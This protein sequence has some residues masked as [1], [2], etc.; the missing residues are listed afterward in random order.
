M[1]LDSID[2]KI[3]NILQKDAKLPVKEIA[4]MVSLSTTPVFQR[5]K[6]LEKNGI[7]KSYSAILNRSKIASTTTVFAEVNLHSHSGKDIEK[8][9]KI[10]ASTPEIIECYHIT[11]KS[12]YLLKIEVSDMKTYRKFI[13]SKMSKIENI[14]HLNS[15]ITLEEVKRNRHVEL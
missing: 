9:E 14:A 11:G 3:L 5:I 1:E 12:D 6:R 4:E 2:K 8:F 13:M 15:S 7:I 10:M